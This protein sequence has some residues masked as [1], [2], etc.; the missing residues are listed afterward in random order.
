[1]SR[2]IKIDVLSQK[3]V[4]RADKFSYLPSDLNKF[5]YPSPVREHVMQDKK[6]RFYNK[7]YTAIFNIKFTQVKLFL[8][9]N[10]N[11]TFYL[12]SHF[13]DSCFIFLN[14]GSLTHKS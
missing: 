9:K 10:K 4:P 3:S 14:T 2:S 1:M 13:R 11:I 12:A 5:S 7:N 8:D 6:K